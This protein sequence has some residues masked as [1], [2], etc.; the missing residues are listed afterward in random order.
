MDASKLSSTIAEI[1]ESQAWSLRIEEPEFPRGSGDHPTCPWGVQWRH[2]DWCSLS[3]IQDGAGEEKKIRKMAPFF[4]FV[5][6]TLLWRVFV[7]QDS[8]F[9][10]S[11]WPGEVKYLS[12][13][14]FVIE[15]SVS[16]WT[17]CILHIVWRF[18]NIQMYVVCQIVWNILNN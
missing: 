12:I 1:D 11:V 5:S 18:M 10:G 9:D 4:L 16:R 6:F 17:C 7:L 3:V 14:Y 2:T 8:G 15:N 13:C